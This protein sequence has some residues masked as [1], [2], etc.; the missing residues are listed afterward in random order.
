MTLIIEQETEL[1]KTNFKQILVSQIVNIPIIK[2]I[3]Q[4]KY[5][6]KLNGW[7]ANPAIQAS[8]ASPC[9]FNF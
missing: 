7:N 2:I 3:S 8:Q 6:F 4:G 1:D 9:K 5:R